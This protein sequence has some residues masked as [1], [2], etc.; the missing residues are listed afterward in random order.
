MDYYESISR[1]NVELVDLKKSGI[2]EF[3]ERGIRTEDGVER[4]ADVVVMCTGYDNMTG[5][6]TSM[7]IRGADGVDLKERWSDGVNSF[8]GVMSRGCPNMFMIF[9]PQGESLF[10]IKGKGY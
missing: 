5:S 10:L 1:E 6:L 9:G 8:L 4:V 7:G 3:T 2:K